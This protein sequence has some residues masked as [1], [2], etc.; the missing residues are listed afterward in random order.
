M[1]HLV[2][3]PPPGPIPGSSD[4]K[5]AAS[6]MTGRNKLLRQW[7]S[8]H[9]SNPYPSKD[10]K[11]TLAKESGLTTTQVENW[12]TNM[13]RRRRH[14]E[15]T[16]SKNF[17]PQGSPI[18][19]SLAAGLTPLERWRNSPPEE[20]HISPS[21]LDTLISSEEGIAGRSTSH[22]SSGTENRHGGNVWF[23]APF[24][25]GSDTDSL[26][27][28]ASSNSVSSFGTSHSAGSNVSAIYPEN[29]R[30]QKKSTARSGTSQ[31][32]KHPYQCT[33]CKASFKTKFDWSRHEKSVHLSLD[34]WVCQSQQQTAWRMGRLLPQCTFCGIESPTREHLASHDFE[35]CAERPLGERVFARK[36][37]LWQHLKKFH[38][39]QAW[40]GLDLNTWQSSCNATKSRCGFCDQRFFAWSERQDHLAAHFK[41]GWCMSQWVGDWGLERATL[42]LLRRATLPGERT[43]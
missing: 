35:S 13:R 42:D 5:R 25:P 34:S 17:F 16:S 43:T 30:R 23:S 18:P 32:N 37:H 15:R 4:G 19:K 28:G 38:A 21:V 10:E 31:P 27:F 11:S 33:F 6:W 8:C 7:Y 1:P 2:E 3:Q 26:G 39:C 9:Q 22:S 29:A 40:A 24:T 12:F 20:E 14:S 41:G 36:D